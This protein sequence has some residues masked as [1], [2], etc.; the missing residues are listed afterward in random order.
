MRPPP[1]AGPQ[2][3]QRKGRSGS[4]NEHAHLAAQGA[5]PRFSEGPESA[6][7]RERTLPA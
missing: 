2:A 5:S 6:D 1:Q 3:A 7:R 4:G